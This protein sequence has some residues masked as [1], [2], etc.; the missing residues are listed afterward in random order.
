MREAK[1]QSNEA[2]SEEI[3]R[4]VSDGEQW[5]ANM[6]SQLAD[7]VQ[8]IV[9]SGPSLAELIAQC[10][11]LRAQASIFFQPVQRVGEADCQQSDGKFCQVSE[12][13]S[14]KSQGPNRR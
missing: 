7:Q 4:V 8:K 13:D 1:Q 2:K 14:P 9:S 5:V 10:D 11:A 3:D 12:D 6:R